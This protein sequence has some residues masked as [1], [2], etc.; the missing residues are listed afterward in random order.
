[1][2]H[3]PYRTVMAQLLNK[4]TL[5]RAIQLKRSSLILNLPGIIILSLF[6]FIV[7]CGAYLSIHSL[8]VSII[9][10]FFVSYVSWKVG[11]AAGIT[12]TVLDLA[13]ASLCFRLLAPENA[14]S[15]T[16]EAVIL[17]TIEFG[18]SF[19]LGYFGK[20]ASELRKE[21]VVRTK[22]E[23][24]LK[25]YQ[26]DLERMVEKRTNELSAANEKLRQAEKME[27][28][29][30]MAGGIAHDFKHYLDIILVDSGLAL[31]SL[32]KTMKAFGHV[33]QIGKTAKSAED[34]TS[35]LL[36]FARKNECKMERVDLNRLIT[37]LI[38][39]VSRTISKNITINFI[40]KPQIPSI[41]GDVTQIR[42][43]LLN[44]ALNARDAMEKGGVLTFRIDTIQVTPEYCREKG[45][46]CSLGNYIGVSVIDTGTGIEPE[47]FK[48]LF[49]PFYTTKEEGKGT[50]MGLPAVFGIAQSHHG[51]AFAAET[52]IGNGS[53]FIILFPA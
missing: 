46:V 30:Q 40:P 11:A 2:T 42:N 37:E 36:T 48:H 7:I 3:S 49:E 1:M 51:T 5:S 29:G 19:L 4:A 53:T 34:F 23:I 43:G 14:R 10:I 12:M 38:P 45:I 15:I 25:K 28:I 31:M 13:W 21:I 52:Q 18:I 22:A 17:Y 8:A 39:L 50:G 16:I 32:D 24:L 26:D 33:A 44:L 47:V 9:S 27:A 35:Q 6:F 41:M 20:L